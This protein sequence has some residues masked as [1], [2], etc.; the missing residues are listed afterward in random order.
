M[1][2]QQQKWLCSG[3]EVRGGDGFQNQNMNIFSGYKVKKRN[4][5]TLNDIKMFQQH[6]ILM[7]MGYMLLIDIGHPCNI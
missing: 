2:N 1:V 4:M 7:K 3:F 6:V 5:S